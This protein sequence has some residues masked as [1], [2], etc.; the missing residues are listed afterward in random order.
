MDYSYTYIDTKEALIR[1]AK[2]WNS[3][4]ILGLDLECENNLH[5][6][7]S[8]LSIFQISTREKNWILDVLK[9]K[10]LDPFLEIL[11]NPKIQK[12]FHGVS[13]DFRII[14]HEFGFLPKNVFD[15]QIAAEFIG[16]DEIGLGDLLMEF[17]GVKKEC[18]MQMAD[19]T[20]RPLT[21]QMLDYAV[22]DSVYMIR[23][24]DTLA[25]KLK[26]LERLD[27]AEEE[28]KLL[29]TQEFSFNE[30]SFWSMKGLRELTDT[31]RAILKR[32][33][34][35]REKLAKQVDRPIHFVINNR[36]LIEIATGT[37][38]TF[39]EW[40]NIRSVHPIVRHRAGQFFAEVKK[41]QKEKIPY[42]KRQI[43]RFTEEQKKEVY[44]LTE[45]REKLASSY[46]IKSH[47]ILSKDQIRE[48][49]VSGN[50]DCL[51]KW[52]RE[53]VEKEK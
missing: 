8:Y 2:E 27:W 1:V 19:W 17:F 31:E 25:D 39:N 41:G 20:K 30:F 12:V 43:K 29:E 42:P 44:R 51:R 45:L 6:Y 50:R 3:V 13:F 14:K 11:K 40:V 28:M 47:L 7:G 21:K 33:F 46:G 35:L 23:L 10:E 15:T 5:H 37:P 4:D 24:R 26:E 34:D 52:Q 53:L 38:L 48:V 16:R 9:L 49:V 32:L 22:K 36:R 18:V